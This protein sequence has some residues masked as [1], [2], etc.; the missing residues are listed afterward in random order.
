MTFPIAY[1]AAACI[2]AAT[3]AI[4]VA[5]C[6][7]FRGRKV[8]DQ[9]AAQG[10]PKA[11][12]TALLGALRTPCTLGLA[13]SSAV[14]YSNRK[15]TNETDVKTDA[16][17]SFALSPAETANILTANSPKSNSPFEL[18]IKEARE[19]C[20]SLKQNFIFQ[21]IYSH[22]RDQDDVNRLLLLAAGSFAIKGKVD[23]TLRQV[24]Q[25]L[26]CVFLERQQGLRK[27]LHLSA[28]Q[29]L[30]HQQI[31]TN[32]TAFFW[33]TLRNEFTITQKFA[34]KEYNDAAWQAYPVFA[35]TCAEVLL[36]HFSPQS[37]GDLSERCYHAIHEL[38]QASK[39]FVQTCTPQT[40]AMKAALG[41]FTASFSDIA[42]KME[43][44]NP[45]LHQR[46]STANA[47]LPAKP[48]SPILPH[49]S[50]SVVVAAVSSSSSVEAEPLATATT[51]AAV[52]SEAET[53]L[54]K[55]KRAKQPTPSA[56]PARKRIGISREL[57]GLGVVDT[58][59]VVLHTTRRR[60]T[61]VT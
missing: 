60:S 2:T 56:K 9:T 28:E 32:Y 46:L 59:A 11:Q 41:L 29:T 44:L 24:G 26:H 35:S 49:P 12:K 50:P 25:L 61:R 6:K 10:N 14:V 42:R 1:V 21:A 19:F 37:E 47:P 54:A 55:E 57:K 51:K 40:D 20:V 30:T 15:N 5:Y 31:Q 27:K 39:D 17:R 43:A 13:P 53:P 48:S 36:N 33:T 45:E 18:R 16:V 4:T 52:S 23:Q 22:S 7:C 58:N 38:E 3:S 8:Q 34:E